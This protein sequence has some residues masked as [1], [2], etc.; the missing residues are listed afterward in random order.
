MNVTYLLG[1]DYYL[2]IHLRLYFDPHL[3]FSYI[4]EQFRHG[5]SEPPEYVNA[6]FQMTGIEDEVTPEK[7]N[8]VFSASGVIVGGNPK[9]GVNPRMDWVTTTSYIV[10]P[11]ITGYCYYIILPWKC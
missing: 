7:A 9:Y 2:M 4:E 1:N 3:A 5:L 11:R 6:H 8:T 10:D